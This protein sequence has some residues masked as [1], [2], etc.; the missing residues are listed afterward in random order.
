MALRGRK[1]EN[2]DD[3][4]LAA[5]S[6]GLLICVSSISFWKKLHWLASTASDRK[7]KGCQILVK[8]WI[9]DDPF[10]KKGPLLV[11]LGPGMIQSSSSVN[12]LMKWG[13]WG[14][15]GHWGFWGCWG[16]WGCRDSKAWKMITRNFRVILV[17]K[18]SFILMFWKE[19]FW[20][21][22]MK[23]QVEL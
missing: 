1:I 8:N 17:L 20:V 13:C 10:L 16:H 5:W 6:Q 3:I 9:F 12:F 23:Y 2:F 11:I 19:K 7:A 21:R 14:H 15:W 4:S 18:F 22:I